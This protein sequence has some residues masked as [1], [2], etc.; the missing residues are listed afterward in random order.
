M[1]F[2][3][4]EVQCLAGSSFTIEELSWTE[5]GCPSRELFMQE[6]LYIELLVEAERFAIPGSHLTI[7]SFDG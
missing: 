6:S 5:A 2:L 4:W 1:Q 7:A 3:R